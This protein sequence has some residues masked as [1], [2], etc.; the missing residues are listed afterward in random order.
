MKQYLGLLLGDF[1]PIVE[2]GGCRLGRSEY[3]AQRNTGLV[4]TIS[5]GE[6]WA[7]IYED[8]PDDER[9]SG[10]LLGLAVNCTCAALYMVP[11]PALPSCF[12]CCCAIAERFPAFQLVGLV[13]WLLLARCA[14][15]FAVLLLSPRNGS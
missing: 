3:W 2:Y 9:A 11:C 5:Q 1:G 10:G 7:G 12:F 14:F 4:H 8:A 15:L 6:R 13:S